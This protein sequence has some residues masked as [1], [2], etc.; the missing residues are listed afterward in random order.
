MNKVAIGIVGLP[1]S[2]KG[3]IADYLQKKYNAEKFRFS[4]PLFETLRFYSL[5]ETRD[6]LIKVSEALRGAFGEDLLSHALAGKVKKSNAEVIV[7]D[8][9]RRESDIVALKT[10][11]GFHLVGIDADVKLRYERAKIRAE[12]P[13]EATMTFEDFLANE[14]RSTEVSAKALLEKTEIVFDNNGDADALY[15]QIDAYLKKI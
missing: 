3:T 9:V 15:V 5:S 11:P 2:G 7:I 12:K 14:K 13:E 4:D 1:A 8:G 6:N 10:L